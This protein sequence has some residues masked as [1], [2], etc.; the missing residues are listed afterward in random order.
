MSFMDLLA[1]RKAKL[2]GKYQAPEGGME[3]GQHEVGEEVMEGVRGDTSKDVMEERNKRE[4]PKIGGNQRKNLSSIV[5]R[6]KPIEDSGAKSLTPKN[7]T[8]KTSAGFMLVNQHD[9]EETSQILLFVCSRL[10]FTCVIC[11]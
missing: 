10:V 9:Q 8:I 5:K 6:L 4:E 2:G 11:I 3:R 7:G 1:S